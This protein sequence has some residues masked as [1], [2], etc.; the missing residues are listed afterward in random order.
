MKTLC[1]GIASTMRHAVCAYQSMSSMGA[2]DMPEFWLQCEIARGLRCGYFV[3]L[4]APT[5]ALLNW[6]LGEKRE[7]ISG[8]DGGKI[9]LA[10]FE[11]KVNPK[12]AHLIGLIEVKKIEKPDDCNEDVERLRELCGNTKSHRFS[13]MSPLAQSD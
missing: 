8:L 10:L 11:Q 4:E 12:E 13:P 9:D 1:D 7:K 2:W 6:E 3:L 5:T